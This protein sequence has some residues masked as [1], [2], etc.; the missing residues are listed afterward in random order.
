VLADVWL[1]RHGVH[2]LTLLGPA[3]L[4][5]LLALG[6]DARAWLRRRRHRVEPTDPVS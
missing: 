1:S 5:G 2:T 3:L 4:I 6:A